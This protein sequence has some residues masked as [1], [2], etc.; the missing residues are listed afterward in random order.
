MVHSPY[1]YNFIYPAR[2]CFFLVPNAWL[3]NPPTSPKKHVAELNNTL[4]VCGKLLL[5]EGG[6]LHRTSSCSVPRLAHRRSPHPEFR[7]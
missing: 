1:A 4:K 5:L 6:N 7:G 2:R 3:N